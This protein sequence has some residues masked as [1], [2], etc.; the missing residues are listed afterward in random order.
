MMMFGVGL[1]LPP[2]VGFMG[3]LRLE[4]GGLSLGEG[5]ASLLVCGGFPTSSI[6]M[7]SLSYEEIIPTLGRAT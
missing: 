3:L 1:T 6:K 5:Q 7:S 2:V 4:I